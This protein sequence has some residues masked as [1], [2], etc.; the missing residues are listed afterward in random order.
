MKKSVNKPRDQYNENQNIALVAESP[1]ALL[2]R[3]LFNDKM[4]L[5]N[6]K[7]ATVGLT[8]KARWLQ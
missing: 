2:Y 1:R 4:A 3:T 5:F 7:M 8:L 6:D